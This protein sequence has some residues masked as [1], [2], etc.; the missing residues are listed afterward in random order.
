MPDY[1]CD[2]VVDPD[3]FH[4]Y[5]IELQ[6]N[7]MPEG[8]IYLK[9]SVINWLECVL[10]EAES[11]R[12]RMVLPYLQ[13][14]EL[15]KRV[16]V[17]DSIETDS[18]DAEVKPISE[19]KYGLFELRTKDV[20]I[21]GWFTQRRIFVGAIGFLRDNAAD[22]GDFEEIKNKVFKAREAAPARF[23]KFVKGGLRDVI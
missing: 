12:R 11:R 6:A 16:I 14:A 17:G 7:E 18:E 19:E 3:S 4:E 20:R 21:V 5:K 22:L 8:K 13:I 23:R 1:N 9:G 10:P 2:E 15:I